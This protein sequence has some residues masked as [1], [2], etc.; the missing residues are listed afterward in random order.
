[1][2]NVFSIAEL[3]KT[4]ERGTNRIKRISSAERL[5][6][7]V[8][9]TGNLNHRTDSASGNNSRPLLCGLEKDMFGTEQPMHLVR[10]CPGRE[11]NVHQ[12]LLGLFDRLRDCDRYF[13]RFP[14]S[15]PNPSLSITDHN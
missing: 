7:D 5:R 11:G 1:M 2:K 12:V 6:N 10:N 9:D 3:A 14:L 15:N 8:M 4:V 13:G